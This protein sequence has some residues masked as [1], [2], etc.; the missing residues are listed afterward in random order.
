MNLRFLLAT[1]L[2]LCQSFVLSDSHVGLNMYSKVKLQKLRG[3]IA[4]GG[5]LRSR[6]RFGLP[7]FLFLVEGLFFVERK[8]DFFWCGFLR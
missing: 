1:L 2:A 8:I 5:F 4:G 3:P 6:H 7:V